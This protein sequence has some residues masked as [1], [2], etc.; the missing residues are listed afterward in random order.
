MAAEGFFEGRFEPLFQPGDIRRAR[1]EDQIAGRYECA[2]IL[3]PEAFGHR[4]EVGHDDPVTFAEDDA[5][6][7]RDIGLHQ[8]L[9]PQAA[10]PAATGPPQPR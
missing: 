3:Q 10:R 7:Q 8:L 5:V 2:R 6:E 9:N 1:L 4:L